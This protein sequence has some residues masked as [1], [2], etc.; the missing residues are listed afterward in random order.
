MKITVTK[1]DP[2]VD[3]EPYVVNG[4]VP[5]KE[6]MTALEALVYF[7]ENVQEIAMDYYCRGRMCGRCAVMLDGEPTLACAAPIDDANHSFEPLNGF[8]VV[9][10][11]V[12]D[13]HGLHDKLAHL[14]KR[15]RGVEATHEEIYAPVDPAKNVHISALE[16]CA[17]CGVCNASCPVLATEGGPAKYIGPAGMISIAYRYYDPLDHG[18]RIEQAVQEG[19]FNCMQ[20]GKCDEVCSALEI[21][22]ATIWNELR[23]AATEAG[24][25]PKER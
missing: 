24:L 10:D 3:A 8:P 4:D 25:A 1:Y 13:R 12:V 22:H 14:R 2:S 15:V 7:N 18:N 5:W 23:A 19:L 6:H 21:D 11:L 20:C 16:Y 17:R 9:R